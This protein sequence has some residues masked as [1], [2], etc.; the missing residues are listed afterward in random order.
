MVVTEDVNIREN[1]VKHI[2]NVLRNFSEGQKLFKNWKFI[3]K[4][5]SV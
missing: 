3:F 5:T 1:W 2:R 4:K